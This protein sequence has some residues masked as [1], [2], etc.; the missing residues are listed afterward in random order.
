[1]SSTSTLDT[2]GG[3][4]YSVRGSKSKESASGRRTSTTPA[5]AGSKLLVISG[6]DGYEDFETSGLGEQ[7][8]HDDSTNH[9]LLWHV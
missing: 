1:M 6:G 8:G 3:K 7:A 2:A 5:S 4:Q 9:L